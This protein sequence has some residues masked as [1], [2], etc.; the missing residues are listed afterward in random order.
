[1]CLV[2]ALCRPFVGTITIGD[3]LCAASGVLGN[4]PLQRLA[5]RDLD[6]LQ[7]HAPGIEF[8]DNLDRPD[9]DHLPYW[10]TALP[11]RDR[12]RLPSIRHVGLVHLDDASQRPPIRIDHGAT[13]LTEKKPGGLIAGDAQLGLELKG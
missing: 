2:F 12:V 8:I 6:A 7:P 5:I 4:E 13:K 9:E 1:M 11:S 3:D 10:A